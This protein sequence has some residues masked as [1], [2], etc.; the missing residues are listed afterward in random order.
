MHHLAL[1]FTNEIKKAYIFVKNPGISI[2][3]RR[4]YPAN[5]AA[6]LPGYHGTGVIRIPATL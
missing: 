3:N 1:E 4:V 2:Y 5:S 6:I